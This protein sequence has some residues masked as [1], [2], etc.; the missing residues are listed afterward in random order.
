MPRGFGLAQ[1][2]ERLIGQG[3]HAVAPF[4]A[5][6]VSGQ[7]PS[8]KTRSNRNELSS[9]SSALGPLLEGGLVGEEGALRSTTRC[10]WL[11]EAVDE[12]DASTAPPS[13]RA[14]AVIAA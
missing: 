7:K 6:P 10:G 11:R 12:H 4:S 1:A 14:G 2:L 8:S 5:S 9:F 13:S 3:D